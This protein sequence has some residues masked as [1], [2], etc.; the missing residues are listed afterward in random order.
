MELERQ[1]RDLLASMDKR[2]KLQLR[3]QQ[4]VE[5]LSVAAVSCLLSYLLKGVPPRSR[6]HCTCNRSNGSSGNGGDL[7]E[8]TQY[9]ARSFRH[10]YREKHLTRNS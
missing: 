2:A 4:T 8:S 1:N 5:G 9:Q 3:L 7:V 6:L 10:R